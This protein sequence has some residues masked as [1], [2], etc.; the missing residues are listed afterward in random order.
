VERC[1]RTDHGL[2]FETLVTVHLWIFFRFYSTLYNL[3]TLKQRRK[4]T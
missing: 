3:Y 2:L 4:I 1:L